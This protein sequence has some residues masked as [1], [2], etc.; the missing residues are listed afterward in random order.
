MPSFHSIGE[1]DQVLRA[2]RIISKVGPDELFRLFETRNP[3]YFNPKQPFGTE[4]DCKYDSQSYLSIFHLATN[5]D[6]LSL[7]KSAANASHAVLASEVVDGTTNFFENIPE[8]CKTEFKKFIAVLV[9]RHIEAV[10]VNSVSQRHLRDLEDVTLADTY[11]GRIPPEKLPDLSDPK[12]EQYAGTLY[13]VFSLLNHSCDPNVHYLNH[14]THGTM[15][16][17]ATRSLKKGET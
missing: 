12:F 14:P 11:S 5:S 2:I 13:S 6:K 1:V 15:I 3:A 10:C 4:P 9:L 8:D 16:V 7:E 17:V